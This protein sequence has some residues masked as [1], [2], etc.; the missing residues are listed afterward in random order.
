MHPVHLDYVKRHPFN[1]FAELFLLIERLDPKKRDAAMLD[2]FCQFVKMRKKANILQSGNREPWGGFWD[3]FT[4]YKRFK[5]ACLSLPPNLNESFMVNS[6]VSYTLSI[7]FGWAELDKEMIITACREF[8]AKTSEIVKDAPGE[9]L[10]TSMLGMIENSRKRIAN[11]DN[12]VEE[13]R[14][15]YS[16]TC[17][18]LARPLLKSWRK[19]LNVP[20]P[21]EE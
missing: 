17:E 18:N 13:A 1:D 3:D 19:R 10:R 2:T 9:E 6:V 11:I 7:R 15:L 5:E 21:A 4:N 14:E 8:I 20:D 12:E 16:Y